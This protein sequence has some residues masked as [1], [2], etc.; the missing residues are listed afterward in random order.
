[1]GTLRLD[2]QDL[3]Q[4]LGR[5]AAKQ[6]GYF[7]AQ[8]ALK[9][10][11]S[12]QAQQYHAERGNW[13][14]VDRG[15]Y[16]FP[17]WPKGLRETCWRWFLWSRG[18]A[19]VSHRAALVCGG[20][21]GLLQHDGPVRPELTVALSFRADPPAELVLHY[22]RVPESEVDKRSG[23]PFTK[24]ERTLLDLAQDRENTDF[25]RV[26][27]ALAVAGIVDVDVLREKAADLGSVAADR[28][29]RA[30]T[31]VTIRRETLDAN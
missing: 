16:C 30:F 19:I 22:D 3:H 5:V 28:L 23:L 25:E 27:V 14:R 12:Y 6:G 21:E 15:L 9:V 31:T 13:T 11:Y 26:V 18:R 7:R 10:G 2:R 20:F 4:R 29:E 17:D 24:P 1:M 8:D